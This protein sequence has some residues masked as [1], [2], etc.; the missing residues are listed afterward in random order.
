[1]Q[2][3]QI[4]FVFVLIGTIPSCFP[5]LFLP[6]YR[7]RELQQQYEASVIPHCR[8]IA[9]LEAKLDQLVAPTV[10]LRDAAKAGNLNDAMVALREGA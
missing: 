5:P 8:T 2:L 7:I 1:M 6:Q 3:G 10:R 9:K 4:D